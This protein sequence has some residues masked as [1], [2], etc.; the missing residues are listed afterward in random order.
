[1]N[2]SEIME[3]IEYDSSKVVANNTVRYTKDDKIFY[4]YFRTDI[5]VISN[6]VIKFNTNGHM[7]YTTR[8]RMNDFQNKLHIYQKNHIWYAR[9]LNTNDEKTV[10]YKDGMMYN[11]NRRIF[12]SE[13]NVPNKKLIRKIKNYS[14]R[15]ANELPIKLPSSED[16][17]N[18]QFN[19]HGKNHLLCHIKENY[20][21]P[22]LLLNVLKKNIC[23]SPPFLGYS[24]TFNAAF[25]SKNNKSKIIHENQTVMQI[26]KER[27][28]K[29]IFKHLMDNLM[30][31]I[32]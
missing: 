11:P 2:K 30:D 26:H 15:F 16:C 10:V 31:H 1:M 4:R 9:E 20:F 3:G 28:Q 24:I 23:V 8:K 13:G 7:S 29:L 17:I 27:I 12:I 6:D 25:K 14:K 21:V 5:L 22:S 32:V 18:C 19:L